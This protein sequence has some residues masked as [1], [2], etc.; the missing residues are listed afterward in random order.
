[1]GLF[2]DIIFFTSYFFV[3]II[4]LTI[5]IIFA[6]KIHAWIWYSIGAIITFFSLI[7]NHKLLDNDGFDNSIA[8]NN[9]STYWMIYFVLLMISAVIIYTRYSMSQENSK[10]FDTNDYG[11]PISNIEKTYKHKKSRFKN[12]HPFLRKLIN[13]LLCIFFIPLSVIA[14]DILL[15]LVL[16]NSIEGVTAIVILFVVAALLFALLYYIFIG[17]KNKQA[18]KKAIGFEEINSRDKAREEYKKGNLEILYLLSPM[19]GGSTNEDN[20]L[21]VPIGINKLKESYDNIIA[22][23]LEQGKVKSYNCQPEYKGESSIPSKI[24]ITSGKNGNIVFKETI[25]IW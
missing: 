18:K 8:I 6:K 24:T 11:K 3:L 14:A 1:M 23:L 2:Y 5:A 19:F 25:H 4:F 12:T 9:P 13:F 15:M 21:Y 7:G 10:E 22:D 17:Q 20:I 16:G